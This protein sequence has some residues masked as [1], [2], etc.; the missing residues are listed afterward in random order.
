M[1]R[2]PQSGNWADASDEDEDRAIQ[3]Q[4]PKASAAAS[5]SADEGHSAAPSSS[6]SRAPAANNYWAQRKAAAESQPQGRPT[7]SRNY[8]RR[9]NYGDSSRFDR[10]DSRGG[11]FDR[12]DSRGGGF[13][14]HDSRGGGFDRQE[15]RGSSNGRQGGGYERQGSRFDRD[16]SNDY[17]VRGGGGRSF[18]RH[19]PTP[20][21]LHQG[22]VKTVREDGGFGFLHCLELKRDVFFHESEVPIR[23]TTDDDAADNVRQVQVGDELSFE[24]TVNRRNGKESAINITRLPKGTIV[25]EDVGTDLVS[26]TVTKGLPPKHKP[27][28]VSSFRGGAAR[29]GDVYGM[30]EVTVADEEGVVGR[31]PLVRFNADSFA[32]HAQPRVGDSVQFYISVHKQTGTKRA[33]ELVVTVSAASKRE[34]AIEAALASLSREQGVVQS[35]KGHAGFIKCLSRLQDAYFSVKDETLAEGDHVSFF[36]LPDD[37]GASDEHTT[38][39]GGNGQR[40]TAIRVEKLAPGTVIF[41]QIVQTDVEATV[42]VAPKDHI[43]Q[44]YGGKQQSHPGNNGPSAGKVQVGDDVLT[45]HLSEFDYTPKEGDVVTVDIL[46]DHRR[47]AKLAVNVRLVTLHPLDREMGSVTSLKEDFGFIKCVDRPGDIYFRLSDV[48]PSSSNLTLRPGAE[49]SFDVV[50]Q[51][52]GKDGTRATR[53][54]LLPKHTIVWEVVV[55]DHASAVLL[56]I[57]PKYNHKKDH[58]T[59]GRLRYRTTSCPLDAF[60]ALRLQLQ[61]TFDVD[62]PT[63]AVSIELKQ[64]SPAQ[65]SAITSYCTL[66]GL[67]IEDPSA[68]VMHVS[69]AAQAARP[70]WAA[71]VRDHDAEAEF[72]L[73]ALSDVRYEPTIGDAV[74]C[75]IVMTKRGHHVLAKAIT[76][77][78]TA[79][80]A[81]EGWVALVKAEGFGFVETT[82]GDSVFFHVTDITDKQTKLKEGD[83]VSFTIKTT[84]KKKKAVA[85]VRLPAGTLPPLEVR[86]L[87]AVVVRASHRQKGSHGH[88]HKKG[89]GPPS[90]AGKLK[91]LASDDAADDTTDT[92]EENRHS[93]LYHL[94]DQVSAS[95]VLR[96]G[97]VVRCQ[98]RGKNKQATQIALVT[99][100]AKTG[101]VELVG[102]QGGTIAVADSDDKV[103]YLNKSILHVGHPQALGVGDKVEFALSKPDDDKPAMATHIV[104][105][106]GADRKTGVNTSLRRVLKENGGVSTARMAKGPDGTKGF[107]AGWQVDVHAVVT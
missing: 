66:V 2:R 7:D 16:D 9:E 36:V 25:L 8:D 71:A 91:I 62:Q 33:V 76:E 69:L 1:F 4:V 104:R 63:E 40:V 96:P 57:P 106:E 92:D 98:V 22:F 51:T 84:D 42:V 10:Q 97:D 5:S 75:S 15:S 88:G 100:N 55:Q 39:R 41:E 27:H 74:T 3:Q 107:A 87:D 31:K 52:K 85:L 29:D 58:A 80:V 48:L 43:R 99:S 46:E 101:V 102:V 54:H 59:H 13:D 64:L 56:S 68:K 67:V 61:T 24:L 38:A 78:P 94:E 32:G 77:V 49:V 70:D 12:Q 21:L 37:L 89:G 35:I 82:H 26:G 53:L 18:E 34:A 86:E 11:G 23:P 93:V 30:I 44:A 20:V 103:A 105:L 19:A 90:T 60:P 17:N 79:G 47:H 72:T 65:R 50:T 14:R 73:D 95:A 45:V 81:G 28:H 6:S 83:E